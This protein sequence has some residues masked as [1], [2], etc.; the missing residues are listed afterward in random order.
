[1]VASCRKYKKEREKKKQIL[2]EKSP[3]PDWLRVLHYRLIKGV[4]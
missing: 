3:V 2:D 4:R 1:M